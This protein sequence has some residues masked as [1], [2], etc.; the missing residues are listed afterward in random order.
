MIIPHKLE[1]AINRISIKMFSLKFLF[2]LNNTSK[3]NP[4]PD[5]NPDMQLPNEIIFSRY[6]S[7]IAMLDAQFGINPIILDNIGLNILLFLANVINISRSIIVFNTIFISNIKI[8][9]F[10]V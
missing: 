10:K 3:P 7:V 6:S 9:I 5:N 8:D 2:C 4:E 1:N